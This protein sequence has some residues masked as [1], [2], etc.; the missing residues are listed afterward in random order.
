MNSSATISWDDETG[1]IYLIDQ[2]RLPG[3]FRLIHCSTVSRLIEAIKRLEVRGAPALGIAGGFGVALAARN[4]PESDYSR[5]LAVVRSEAEL[6][7]VARPTAVNLSWGISRVLAAI[8]GAASLE[9]AKRAAIAEAKIIG[10]EDAERCRQIGQIGAG[11]LPD[12]CTVLTHCNAG[13]LACR[14]WGT[15]LGVV[16]S[17]VSAGK[18]V[19]VIACETRPLLQGAR[20][21][22]WELQ[23]D[24]IEVTVVTDSSAAFLMQQGVVD[25]VIVG[26]DRITKDAVFNKIGTYMHAVCA[27]HHGIPFYVAAPRSSFDATHLA[28]EVTI[29]ERDRA[30]I[31]CCGNIVTMPDGVPAINYAFDRTPMS[32][33]SAIICETGVLRPPINI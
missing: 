15:A 1:S 22:A 33:V 17:A 16:R 24:G 25:L 5:F 3:E 29:E 18:K 7:R 13:A 20:L 21:T 9:S 32:L 8:E 10:E 2:T 27:R 31:A 28:G 4:S 26:A 11:L 23:R 12:S 30:E 14:E 6:I 19:R